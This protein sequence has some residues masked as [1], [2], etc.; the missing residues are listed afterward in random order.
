M[1]PKPALERIRGAIF[2][3]DESKEP[4]PGERLPAI[5]GRRDP[6]KAQARGRGIPDEGTSGRPAQGIL[7]TAHG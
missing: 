1:N 4:I 7:R 3:Q 5:Q 6:P 2:S